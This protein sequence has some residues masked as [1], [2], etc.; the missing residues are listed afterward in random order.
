MEAP[1]D[2]ESD[3]CRKE[4]SA[5]ENTG[6]DAMLDS[7]AINV[8]SSVTEGAT[9]RRRRRGMPIAQLVQRVRAQYGATMLSPLPLPRLG[10][11]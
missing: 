6:V 5:D 8:M 1:D 11:S 2:S 7:A 3:C 4:N 10:R 9:T